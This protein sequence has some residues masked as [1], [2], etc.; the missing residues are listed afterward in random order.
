M[1]AGKSVCRNPVIL[2]DSGCGKQKTPPKQAPAAAP[3]RVSDSAA[4]RMR[5]AREVL[6]R[7]AGGGSK[8]SSASSSAAASATPDMR[9][10]EGR[11]VDT[12]ESRRGNRLHYSVLEPFN[13]VT[14]P[15]RVASRD[16]EPASAERFLQSVERRLRDMPN[17]NEFEKQQ[18]RDR[19]QQARREEQ[20]NLMINA[21]EQRLAAKPKSATPPT[22]KNSPP[23]QAAP[24]APARRRVAVVMEAL[25]APA[26]AAAAPAAKRRI[27]V[28]IVPLPA[29]P[30]APPAKAARR[31]S[32]GGKGAKATAPEPTSAEMREAARISQLVLQSMAARA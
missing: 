12:P 27:A 1:S 9:T 17:L 19:A 25:P 31:R 3:R 21:I 30:A 22:P 18:Y 20:F 4:R 13:T 10:A 2:C 24:A 6:G 14:A 29:A 23:K 8:S 15:E 32:G 11:F 5:Y 26:A 16:A 7:K 28:E